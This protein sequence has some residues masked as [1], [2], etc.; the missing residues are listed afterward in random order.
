MVPSPREPAETAAWLARNAVDCLPTGGLPGRLAEAA[1]ERRPL[2]VKLGIDPTAPDIHLGHTVVLSKLREFQD[3]GHVVVLIIG[4]YTARVGDPSGRSS[5]RPLLSEREIEN[6]ARTFAEQAYKVLDEN[7]DR[8][9]V[10]RN[11]EWL[12]MAMADLLA[13]TATTT[14]A[15]LLERDDFAGRLDRNE[16]ISVL[17]LLY[18][19]LQGYDSVAVRSDVELGGTDQKFNLLL[20]RDIQRAYG[21][22][23]QV[24]LTMPI[25]VGTDGREKMSKSLGNHIGVTEAPSEV[26]GKT[27]SVPDT[28]LGDYWQLLLGETAPS[29]LN[30]RDAK[31]ALARRL[32]ARFHDEGQ[33]QQAELGFDRL[34]VTGEEPEDAPEAQLPTANAMVHMPTLVAELFG[35]SGSQARRLLEQG[36]V[37]LGQ[38]VLAPDTQDLAV[39]E[40]EG[41]L[42]R[43][44]KRRFVRL[45]RG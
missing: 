7:P 16:P 9:E 14:V 38:R 43:V 27:L 13:L 34:F 3:L 45:R 12:D 32:V 40:L 5:T 6:N 26:Y 25:L 33:A 10:R 1:R 21:Q 23:E 19:L 2:R 41:Q 11:S 44:G 15:Q 4:D 36:G 24:V 28:A 35:V 37:R 39:E 31:R 18:P 8:L 30:A 22:S 29:E 17:E 20:A 42:L